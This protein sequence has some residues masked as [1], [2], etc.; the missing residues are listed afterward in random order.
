MTE[1]RRGQGYSDYF[2]HDPQLMGDVFGRAI[3]EAKSAKA[4]QNLERETA[5]MNANRQK[6]DVLTTESGLQYKILNPGNQPLVSPDDRVFTYKGT[7]L[8]TLHMV[9]RATA[10]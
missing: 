10:S 6:Y 2:K 9:S 4:R 5:F 3:E 8:R 7:S 1:K